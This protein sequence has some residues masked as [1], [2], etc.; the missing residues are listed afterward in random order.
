MLIGILDCSGQILGQVGQ[1]WL[2]IYVKQL[3]LYYYIEH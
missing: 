2:S 3:G 1:Y